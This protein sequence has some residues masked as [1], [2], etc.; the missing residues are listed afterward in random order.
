MIAHDNYWLFPVH[1]HPLLQ[2]LTLVCKPDWQYHGIAVKYILLILLL[3]YFVLVNSFKVF[4]LSLNFK[5][6]HQ[7]NHSAVNICIDC[8]NLFTF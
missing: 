2:T 4:K 8:M 5:S 3:Q 7:N 6:L 1:G